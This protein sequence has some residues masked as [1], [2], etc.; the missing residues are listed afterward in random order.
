MDNL[1]RKASLALIAL[2]TVFLLKPSF[3]LA[4]DGLPTPPPLPPSEGEVRD[5]TVMGMVF[6]EG[7]KVISVAV[8]SYAAVD[9]NIFAVQG[10]GSRPAQRKTAITYRW[11]MEQPAGEAK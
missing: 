4:D 7:R 1:N 6:E 8:G 2:A 3:A 5:V 10:L 9:V 11:L